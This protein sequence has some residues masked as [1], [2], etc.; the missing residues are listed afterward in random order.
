MKSDPVTGAVNVKFQGKMG[1]KKIVIEGE[2]FWHHTS[3]LQ[4]YE[5]NEEDVVLNRRSI[6]CFVQ[7][8]R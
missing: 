7:P 1:K 8:S 2:I 4:G 3:F 6:G 5:P